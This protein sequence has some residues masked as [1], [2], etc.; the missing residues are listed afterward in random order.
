MSGSPRNLGSFGLGSFGHAFGLELGVADFHVDVDHR[1]KLTLYNNKKGKSTSIQDFLDELNSNLGL[2]L[3]ATMENLWIR[4]LWITLVTP[5]EKSKFSSMESQLLGAVKSMA[6]AN[7]QAHHKH[8]GELIET[9]LAEKGLHD[10]L[11]KYMSNYIYESFYYAEYLF[12][13]NGKEMSIFTNSQTLANSKYRFTLGVIDVPCKDRNA[14][15][16]YFD[17][18]TIKILLDRWSE[19][20]GMMRAF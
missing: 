8:W 17:F 4:S 14:A 11:V 18:D 12:V 16:C 2:E 13:V 20:K 10:V 1:G 15:K 6:V 7:M 3:S 19:W 9:L 5:F